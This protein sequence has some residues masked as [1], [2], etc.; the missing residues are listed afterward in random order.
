[1]KRILSFTCLALG[2]GT[3]W[4]ALGGEPHPTVAERLQ[5]QTPA[6]ATYWLLRQELASGTT[7]QQFLDARGTVFAV[8]WSGPFLPDLRSLLG[9]H[10]QTLEQQQAAGASRSAVVVR[11]DD[12]VLVSAGRMGAFEGRAWLPRL[13]PAGFDPGQLP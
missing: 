7:V 6:A 4:A 8:T 11:R 5:R 9:T 10:F 12:L 3:C 1:M 13:L 2:A